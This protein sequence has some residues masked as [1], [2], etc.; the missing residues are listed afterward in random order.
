VLT[1]ERGCNESQAQQ[2]QQ[3]EATKED[4]PAG[5]APKICEQRPKAVEQ[6]R[7][8][9]LLLIKVWLGGRLFIGAAGTSVLTAAAAGTG[10]GAAARTA[11]A[12]VLR[13]E[14]DII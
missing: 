4:G 13:Q 12:L 6:L 14:Q 2:V 1:D 7:R 5:V 11:K 8:Q 9:Q 10:A 3:I